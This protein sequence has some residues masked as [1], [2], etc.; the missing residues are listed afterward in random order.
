MQYEQGERDMVML[1]HKFV[2]EHQDGR[3][4]TRT[5]TLC[6]NGDPKTYFAMTPVKLVL[7]GTISDKGILAP[8]HDS[9]NEPLMRALRENYGIECHEKIIA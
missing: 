6:E 8:L 2:I 7:D 4:E 3:R 5:S 1:Q 9:I